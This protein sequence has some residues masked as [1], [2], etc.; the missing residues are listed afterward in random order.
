MVIFEPLE[1]CDYTKELKSDNFLN[2]CSVS[3]DYGL[4]IVKK[5]NISQAYQFHVWKD[6]EVQISS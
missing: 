2:T 6:P 3:L 4:K 1:K 5:R